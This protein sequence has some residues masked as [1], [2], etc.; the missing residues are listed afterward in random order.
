MKFQNIIKNII[1]IIG[2]M[3]I[4]ILIP[5]ILDVFVFGNNVKSNIIN[6][7][8]V[9]FLGSYSGSVATLITLVG[10]V[11][12]TNHCN[13]QEE[14]R[15][16]MRDRENLR[17]QMQPWLD[18][19]IDI[20]NREGDVFGLNDRSFVIEDDKVSEMRFY[21]RDEDRERMRQ[22]TE[23]YYYLKYSVV[24]VGADNAV[25]MKISLNGFEVLYSIL[26]NET[27]NLF[28][29]FNMSRGVEYETE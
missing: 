10:T 20:A 16:Y 28:L 15:N 9:T 4:V 1:L 7:E 23:K 26:K 8:W 14:K 29:L 12:Y 27:I 19:R 3:I 2:L 6:S 18:K 5:C 17:A 11:L 25:R 22:H 24:N 13:R 21:L